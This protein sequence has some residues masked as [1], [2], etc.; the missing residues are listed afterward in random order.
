MPWYVKLDNGS[1][2]R[3]PL[4]VIMRGVRSDVFVIRVPQDEVDHA[5]RELIRRGFKPTLL[6]LNKGE[7]Y[8]L[9]M[10]IEPPWEIHVRV[11]PDGTIGSEV[12]VS[13]D[14]LQ[15]LV[16]PR[17]NVVYEIY[18]LLRGVSNDRRIC[19]KPLGR[20]VSDVIENI[21]IE[22]RAPKSLIP[23]KPLVAAASLM[24]LIP[25]MGRVR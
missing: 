10:R 18:E 20:C 8:S 7:R 17:F 13:R 14:Y 24:A 15:H 11:F 16:G 25:V 19:V 21:G 4:N 2:Y 1:R 9:T 12:E 5:A 23:W 3:I 6:A 22:L